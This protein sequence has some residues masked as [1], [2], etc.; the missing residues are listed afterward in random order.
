M[1]QAVAAVK[2]EFVDNTERLNQLELEATRL[3][4]RNETLSTDLA[5]ALAIIVN[6]TARNLVVQVATLLLNNEPVPSLGGGS[7]NSL[8]W[9]GRERDED[10]EDYRRRC[11]LAATKH[12]S[13]LMQKSGRKR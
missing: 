1:S 12:V 11:L 9:D 4:R 7:D 2:K 8:P 3:T 13:K 5:D 10:E 6:D